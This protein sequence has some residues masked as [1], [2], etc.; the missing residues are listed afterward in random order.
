MLA[1]SYAVQSRQAVW[2]TKPLSRVVLFGVLCSNPHA[3]HL[4]TAAARNLRHA[5]ASHQ[6]IV[7]R[8]PI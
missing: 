7:R 1:P 8:F 6:L 5:P 4:A 3:P 2:A